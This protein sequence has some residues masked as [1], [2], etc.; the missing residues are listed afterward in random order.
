MFIDKRDHVCLNSKS[1]FIT[2]AVFLD[3]L[4]MQTELNLKLLYYN[5]NCMKKSEKMLILHAWK[6]SYKQ[7]TEA[8]WAN[9][10]QPE[11]NLS[12]SIISENINSLF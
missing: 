6:L 12:I 4:F 1:L 9:W 2:P 8:S 5:E 7:W 10:I 3:D 11:S